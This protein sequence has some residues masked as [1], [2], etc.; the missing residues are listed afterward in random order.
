MAQTLLEG[1]L[2]KTSIDAAIR[3]IYD[4]MFQKTGWRYKASAKDVSG[5]SYITGG[6]T[7]G[8]C[9][10]YRN[11]FAA[12]L[13]IYDQLRLSHPDDRIK[14]GALN[15]VLGN[16]LAAQ[17]FSTRKGLML[18]G[19][20]ALKGNVYL[21]VDGSGNILDQGLDSINTFVFLGHWTLKVNA[22]EYDPIFHSIDKDNVGNTLDM[23]YSDGVGRFLA[24]TSN[25]IPTK[26]F[27]AT[28][29][30]VTDFGTFQGIVQDIETL[31]E[32]NTS[33]VE[34]LLSGSKLKQIQG[35]FR[36]KRSKV[37][38]DAADI[39]TRRIADR[40]TFTRVVDVAYNAGKITRPQ[41]K[42]CDK[43]SALV[44]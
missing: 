38:K 18:M 30:H 19:G 28:F 35:L 5:P 13:T 16:D 4:N 39:V 24:D 37:A 41:K 23:H 25:P 17:R 12:I 10:S 20:T 14:N 32:T 40:A 21:Q 27:G 29:V 31:Y 11:A 34:A 9:E 26:E 8:M 15:I 3:Q 2:E 22:K 43:L 7:E 44:P 42:A 33:D 1:A 36:P 6:K